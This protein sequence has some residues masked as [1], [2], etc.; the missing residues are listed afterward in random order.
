MIEFNYFIH[1]DIINYDVQIYFDIFYFTKNLEMLK[2]REFNIELEFL[3]E[4]NLC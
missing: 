3:L 1:N 4:S 2:S